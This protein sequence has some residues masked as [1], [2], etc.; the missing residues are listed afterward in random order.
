MLPQSSRRWGEG[1]LQSVE[2][3]ETAARSCESIYATVS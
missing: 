2:V 1:G 3:F